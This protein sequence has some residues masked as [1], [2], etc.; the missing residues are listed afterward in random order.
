MRRGTPNQLINELTDTIRKIKDSDI[1]SSSVI[2]EEEDTITAEE[3]IISPL[4]EPEE[5]IET[6]IDYDEYFDK[7]Y[8]D[9]E[10]KIEDLV[11]DVAWHSDDENLYMDANFLDGHVVTFTIPKADLI[12]DLENNDMDVEYIC[13][14][15]RDAQTIDDGSL[16]DEPDVYM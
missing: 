13:Q 12:Y 9:V 4:S 5:S 10:R 15:V 8:D 14:S 11:Q 6:E 3:D 16:V 7:L 2:I 1:D